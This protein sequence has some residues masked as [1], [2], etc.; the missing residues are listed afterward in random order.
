MG[1]DSP[2]PSPSCISPVLS[3]FSWIKH[4]FSPK[5]KKKD[6]S[7][8]S[9]LKLL[10]ECFPTIDS[11]KKFTYE[12]KKKKNLRKNFIYTTPN[13]L[14]KLHTH[15]KHVCINVIN[16]VPF[17]SGQNGWNF[18]YRLENRN[19]NILC[20]TSAPIPTHFGQFWVISA[21]MNEFCSLFS[22]HAQ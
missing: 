20:S 13:P 22:L 18:L 21:R 15:F 10:F 5:K 19:K 3:W 8:L 4:L 6:S 17:R 2:R 11:M 12:K 7:Q 14:K 9:L 1:R 16:S